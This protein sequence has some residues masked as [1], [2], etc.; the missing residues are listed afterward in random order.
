M[1]MPS[2]ERQW[3]D[4]L[5]AAIREPIGDSSRVYLRLVARFS[6]INGFRLPSNLPSRSGSSEF[7][8]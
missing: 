3:S 8:V 6:G 5:P 1:P 4:G 7:T 2:S